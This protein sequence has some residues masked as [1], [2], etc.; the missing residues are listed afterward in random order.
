MKDKRLVISGNIV[1]DTSK[2]VYANLGAVINREVGVAVWFDGTPV[3]EPA[4][5]TG[6]DAGDVT[7]ILTAAS[8][9]APNA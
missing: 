4:T 3:D 7:A 2:V 9:V 8:E 1:L 6:G 5:F